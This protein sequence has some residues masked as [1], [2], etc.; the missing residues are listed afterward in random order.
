MGVPENSTWA[1]LAIGFAGLGLL[2]SLARVSG[3]GL[4]GTTK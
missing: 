2:S 3:T 1:M 4:N